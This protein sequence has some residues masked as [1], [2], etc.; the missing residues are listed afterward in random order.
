MC[1]C[2]PV[3]HKCLYG[4]TCHCFCTPAAMVCCICTCNGVTDTIWRH[5]CRDMMQPLLGHIPYMAVQGNLSTHRCA[6]VTCNLICLHCMQLHSC[7]QLICYSYRMSMTPAVA[8]ALVHMPSCPPPPAFKPLHIPPPCTYCE[9]SCVCVQATMSVIGRALVTGT[10]R[11]MPRTLEESVEW[12]LRS[13]SPC[14]SPTLAS[15]GTPLLLLGCP[16]LFGPLLL[17]HILFVLG[18]AALFSWNDLLT[19]AIQ[20][21][22]LLCPWPAIFTISSC[23]S[24]HL[25]LS[26]VATALLFFICRQP[27]HAVPRHSHNLYIPFVVASS[28][29]PSSD[30]VPDM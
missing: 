4:L 27:W 16:H 6:L 21:S 14:P 29:S 23:F 19:S 20:V 13:A 2:L 25:T 5:I 11:R 3:L 30:L 10:F 9:A 24:F 26:T 22:A 8:S 18:S 15:N 12:C 7:S 28:S 17:L 1:A